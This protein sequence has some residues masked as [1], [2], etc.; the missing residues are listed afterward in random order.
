ME[1]FKVAIIGGGPGGYE[2]AIRFNQLGISVICFEKSRLGGVCLNWGCIPTKALV[3]VADLYHEMINADEFGLEKYKHDLDYEKVFQRKNQVV[4]KLVGGI[5]FLFKKRQIPVQNKIVTK[6]KKIDNLFEIF[7]NEELV[8]CVEKVIIATGS[9]PKTLPFL[10][11]DG[12]HILSSDHILSMSELPKSLI[13]IGGGVIGCEFACIYKQLGV[14]VNIVEFLPDL[15]PTEDEEISKRIAM[16]LKKL[17]IKIFTKTAVES[18]SINENGVDLVL[19]N[20][21]RLSSEKVLVSVGRKPVFDIETLNF[22]LVKNNNF[23]EIDDL[24]KTSENNVFAIGDVTGKLM[25]AHTASKQG[26]LVADYINS[27]LNNQ[28]MHLKPLAYHNIPSCTFTNPEVASCGLTEKQANE[29]FEEIKVGRFPFAANGKALGSGSIFGFVKT[30]IN[31]KTDEII[32]MHIIGH[33]ATELIAQASILINTK[34]KVE[35]VANIVFAHP[36]ISECVMESIEDTHKMAI[37]T[38]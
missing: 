12:K 32:G 21:K 15:L 5:E 29:K 22:E 35:D 31:A 7:S 20:S 27:E 37:H 36:T 14:D 2:T 28:K 33:L 30:I 17:G 1:H 3:K 23:L 11:F 26:L 4:E 9:E 10:P 24:C 13:I 16:A 8:C 38:V 6:I 19:S 18:G 25:L 34:A